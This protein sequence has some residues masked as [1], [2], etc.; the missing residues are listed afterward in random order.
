M[1]KS[2]LITAASLLGVSVASVVFA[3]QSVPIPTGVGITITDIEGIVNIIVNSLIYI[4]GIVIIGAFA[5]SGIL[6]ASSGGSEGQVDKAKAAFMAALY[7]TLVILGIYL[8]IATIR[9]L[10]TGQFFGQ[11]FG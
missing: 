7:G 5:Y 2:T 1:K 4:A 6:W 11:F 9:G 8:I 10:V 3:A